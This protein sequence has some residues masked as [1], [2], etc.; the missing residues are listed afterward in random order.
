[1]NKKIIWIIVIGV[2]AISTVAILIQKGILGKDKGIKVATEKAAYRTIIETVN[3]SG[4]IYPEF[5]VKV[6]PDV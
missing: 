5:E 6:S 1:M 2:T 3:A 4:K